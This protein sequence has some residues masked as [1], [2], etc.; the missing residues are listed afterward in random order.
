MQGNKRALGNAGG[1]QSNLVQYKIK[2]QKLKKMLK[3]KEQKSFLKK[4]FK[5]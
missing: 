3:S 2:V 1:D 5:V 4:V